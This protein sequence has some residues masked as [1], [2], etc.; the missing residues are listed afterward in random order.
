[1]AKGKKQAKRQSEL[2]DL[3][4]DDVHT[5]EARVAELERCVLQLQ[6]TLSSM[7]RHYYTIP[8]QYTPGT[9]TPNPLPGSLPWSPTQI[10]CGASAI[11]PSNDAVP[12]FATFGM[13]ESDAN[14]V[15]LLRRSMER[16]MAAHP[17]SACPQCHDPL[18]GV[19]LCSDT[20]CPGK[21]SS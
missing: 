8:P 7:P 11:P 20:H 16:S 5:L 6:A 12:A 14:V 13:S 10:W 9:A 18:R 2:L 21:A 3:V 1:M 15:S 4:D 19:M 17:S